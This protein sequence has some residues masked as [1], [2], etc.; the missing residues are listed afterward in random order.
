MPMRCDS[1][2]VTQCLALGAAYA[3]LL[4]LAD[5]VYPLFLLAP[6]PANTAAAK[7]AAAGPPIHQ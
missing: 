4:V 1:L 5:D 3:A 2:P 6:G 7:A